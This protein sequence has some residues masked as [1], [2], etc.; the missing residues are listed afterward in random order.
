MQ[1]KYY[2][3]TA[4][5][6]IIKFL[7]VKVGFVGS[8]SFPGYFWWHTAAARLAARGS[9]TDRVHDQQF[10]DG[11]TSGGICPMTQASGQDIIAIWR[12]RGQPFNHTVLETRDRAGRS[13]ICDAAHLLLITLQTQR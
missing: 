2:A 6:S 13:V 4:D 9:C 8:V 12:E 11:C 1:R 10:T 3:D 7:V 5:F